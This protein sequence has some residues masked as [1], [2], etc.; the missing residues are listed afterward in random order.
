MLVDSP[1]SEGSSKMSS[2]GFSWGSSSGVQGCAPL[3]RLNV[4]SLV[5]GEGRGDQSLDGPWDDGNV[6]G[7]RGPVVDAD[8]G[9][10]VVSGCSGVLSIVA[11]EARAS[12]FCESI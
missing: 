10:E 8:E 5:V 3:V 11:G 1:D 12:W 6:N 7:E 4:S 2:S 9:R